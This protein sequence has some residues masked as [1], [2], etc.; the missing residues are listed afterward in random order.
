[1]VKSP[2][3]TLD[4]IFSALSDPTRRKLLEELALGEKTVTEVAEPFFNDMSL[5]AISKH[6]RILEEAGLIV[7]RKQGR[8]HHL[9]L[10]AAPMKEASEWLDIYRQF[11][12]TQFD[13]LAQFLR[14]QKDN[15][16][17]QS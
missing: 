9:Q 7:R 5:P 11:W 12:D 2:S 17:D 1:M 4:A 6:L 15:P 8:V 13:A 14:E 10:A 16:D 3:H